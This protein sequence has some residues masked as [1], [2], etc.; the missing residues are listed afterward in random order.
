M[1]VVQPLL[2]LSVKGELCYDVVSAAAKISKYFFFLHRVVGSALDLCWSPS[3]NPSTGREKSTDTR[4]TEG[5]TR[6]AVRLTCCARSEVYSVWWKPLEQ[7]G[8]TVNSNQGVL[9]FALLGLEVLHEQKFHQFSGQPIPVLECPYNI[10]F[11]FK[12]S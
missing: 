7:N 12:S 8:S 9:D 6:R 10:V 1:Y 11:F 5:K 4:K 2:K 3:R